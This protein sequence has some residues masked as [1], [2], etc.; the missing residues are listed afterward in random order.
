[1]ERT[2]SILGTERLEQLQQQGG[3]GSAR[4]G[5]P[6]MALSQLNRLVSHTKSFDSSL[7]QINEKI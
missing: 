6:G 3:L 5:I 2:K 1:M 4:R 7:F